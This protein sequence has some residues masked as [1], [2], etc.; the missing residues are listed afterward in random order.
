MIFLSSYASIIIIK[1]EESAVLT[2]VSFDE[3]GQ[4]KYKIQQVDGLSI[5][6][7]QSELSEKYLGY[8]WFIKPRI[9]EDVRSELPEYTMP[10][11]WFLK[12]Y[13]ALK[14]LLSNHSHY[15]CY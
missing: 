12:L 9:T 13:G 15:F 14:I 4:R 1:N 8:C 2:E 5:W 7:T 3:T 11:A 10:K 6:L